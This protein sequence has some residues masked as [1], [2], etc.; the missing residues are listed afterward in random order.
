VAGNGEHIKALVRSHASGDDKSFYAVAMQVAAQAARQGHH[1]LAS[2]LKE[3][4]ESS[5][6]TETR[7][8]VTHIAQPRG[9]LAKLVTATFPTPDYVT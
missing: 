5:R 3:A 9:D 7:P 1:V 2:D 6:R 4:V 8:G